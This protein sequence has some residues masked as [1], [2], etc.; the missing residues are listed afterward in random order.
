MPLHCSQKPYASTPGNPAGSQSLLPLTRLQ[1]PA[2]QLQGLQPV[3]ARLAQQQQVQQE[4]S[5][6]QEPDLRGRRQLLFF[7][8]ALPA[9]QWQAASQAASKQQTYGPAFLQAFQQ[10]LSVDGSF[11]VCMTGPL[12]Q[13][14]RLYVRPLTPLAVHS[15]DPAGQ[16]QGLEPCHSAGA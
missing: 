5:N 6:V 13:A 12:S 16:G 11:E 3:F 9:V 8:A 4:T 2:R 7:A 10:A 15:A 14:L 1:R